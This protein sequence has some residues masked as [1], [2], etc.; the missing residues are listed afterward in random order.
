MKKDERE[1]RIRELEGNLYEKKQC[2][3]GKAH[4]HD[5]ACND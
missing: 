3:E 2:A 4:A 5:S 1:R